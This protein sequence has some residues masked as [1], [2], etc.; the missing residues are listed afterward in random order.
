MEAMARLQLAV[1]EKEGDCD[2]EMCKHRDGWTLDHG[3]RPTDVI[4]LDFCK[5]FDMVT[6]NILSTKLE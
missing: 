1:W 5:A 6:H 3:G 4:Y 2:R